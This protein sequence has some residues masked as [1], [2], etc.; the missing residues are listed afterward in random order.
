MTRPGK[1]QWFVHA[2]VDAI[3]DAVRGGD[4][5]R[6]RGSTLYCGWAA[7][8]GC[9]KVIVGTGVA[10]VVRHSIPQHAERPDWL[11]SIAVADE[12]FLAAGV[13]VEEYHGVLGVTFRF[14]GKLIEV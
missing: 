4:G 9:A 5:D 1:Y 10:K 11:K 7:C 6:I 3:L 8:D 2:E 12:M 14:N 13:R